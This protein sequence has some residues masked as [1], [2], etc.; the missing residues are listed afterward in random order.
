MTL[1][2]APLVGIGT[3]LSIGTLGGTPTFTVIGGIQKITPPEPKYGTE[4][5]TTLATTGNTRV[6]IKT[7]IDPGEYQIEGLNESADAGQI[8]LEAAFLAS[9]NQ[10]N[11]AAYP[12][13]LVLPINLAG[14][15][16]TTG[17][18]EAFNA[19][20]TSYSEGEVT[21]DKTIP[22]KATLTVTG[23]STYTEGS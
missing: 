12:F 6:K 17:D 22:F 19:L 5:V 13:K 20:V 8:A 7:L 2:A 21:I 23:P 10:V 14:G 15:Q 4:D 1:T 9:S 16:A 11:G 3:A 18:T